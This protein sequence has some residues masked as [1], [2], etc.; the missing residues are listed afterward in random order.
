MKHCVWLRPE[1]VCQVR[2]TEWTSGGHLRHP[3]F[4]G[5]REDKSAREVVGEQPV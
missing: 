5:L 1:L 4:V 3:S 2:F